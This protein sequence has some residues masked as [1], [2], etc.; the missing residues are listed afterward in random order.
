MTIILDTVFVDSFQKLFP[1]AYQLYAGRFQKVEFNDVEGVLTEYFVVEQDN[2]FNFPQFF[3]EHKLGIGKK[4]SYYNSGAEFGLNITAEFLASHLDQDIEAL[5]LHKAY[6]L[7]LDVQ[8]SR[9][10]AYS[11]TL[12]VQEANTVTAGN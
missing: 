1:R 4:Y 3:L 5:Q 11:E 7:Q 2:T 6:F 10:K 9:Q 8:E 12:P